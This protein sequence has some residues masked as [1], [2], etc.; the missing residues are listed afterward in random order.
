MVINAKKIPRVVTREALAEPTG[1]PHRKVV[2][3]PHNASWAHMYAA[4]RD[5]ILSKCND[6][7][8]AIEHVGS[9][10]I[11][12]IHAKPIIDLAVGVREL[13]DA[14]KMEPGMIALGYDYPRD[15]GI[16]DQYVFGKGNP[17]KYIVHVQVFG[18]QHWQDYLA[19]R[20]TL[21]SNKG[22]A[23]AYE[24][25][26]LDLA[27]RFPDDRATYTDHKAVFVA[28]VLADS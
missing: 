4:E 7:I 24:K 25:L 15:V 14:D 28:Q 17:R 6:M 2:L 19:F 3:V 12:G 11:P 9:T 1:V 13:S 27:K 5:S 16:P 20:D 10:S 26:K 18:S 22:L 21:K 8:L 23:A